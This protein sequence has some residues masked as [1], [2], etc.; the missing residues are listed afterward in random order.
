MRARENKQAGAVSCLIAGIFIL[1]GILL[2]DLAIAAGVSL[3]SYSPVAG[4]GFSPS[5][6]E[7]IASDPNQPVNIESVAGDGSYINGDPNNHYI[8]CL[9][10][11]KSGYCGCTS[12]AAIIMGYTGEYIKPTDLTYWSGG[13]RPWGPELQRKVPGSWT[14]RTSYKN[15]GMNSIINT[16][17]N[18][19]AVIIYTK[20]PKRNG[21]GG[22]MHIMATT[23]YDKNKDAFLVHNSGKSSCSVQWISRSFFLKN[24]H[25]QVGYAW[26]AP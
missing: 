1:A 14:R 13:R 2:V 19:D 6:G 8:P 18:G 12:A 7:Y 17:R 22:T 26:R 16:I 24:P 11:F 23:Q 25:D 3:A 4:A 5:E 20:Y 21:T 15:D 9:K 10:Q